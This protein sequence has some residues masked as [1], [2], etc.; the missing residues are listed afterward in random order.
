MDQDQPSDFSDAIF[1]RRLR[2]FRLLANMTQQELAAR[3]T[4]AGHKMHRS[5]IAKIEVGERPVS[6]G[7]AVQFGGFLGVPL[8]E[9][10][11]DPGAATDEERLYRARLEA[12]LRV[13]S[14][15]NQAAEYHR[16]LSETQ[17]LIEN[18]EERLRGAEQHLADL[19]GGVAWDEPT[20]LLMESSIPMESLLKDDQ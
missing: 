20:R 7:E 8:M 1:A 2:E 17:V 15:K 18:T 4:A 6:I 9:M 10:V 5:A 12:Q 14:L 11:T 16:L 13:R 19:G 3:M